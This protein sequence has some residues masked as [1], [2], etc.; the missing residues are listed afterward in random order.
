MTPRKTQSNHKIVLPEIKTLG[1]WP[2]AEEAVRQLARDHGIPPE[3]I[4]TFLDEIKRLR[5]DE[6]KSSTGG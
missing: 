6:Q 4:E 2:F 1:K 3:Q 5:A